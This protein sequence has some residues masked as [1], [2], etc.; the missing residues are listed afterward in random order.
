V[1]GRPVESLVNFDLLPDLKRCAGELTSSRAAEWMSQI[2][3][4][5]GVLEVNVNRRIASDGLLLAM[6]TRG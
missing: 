3:E 6:A 1:L 2:E 5:R 4:L